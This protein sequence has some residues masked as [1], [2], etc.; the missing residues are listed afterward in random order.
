MFDITIITQKEYINPKIK[1]WYI[2]QIIEEDEL[3]INELEKLNLK[4]NRVNWDANHQWTSTKVIVVRAIWDYFNRFE[5]F[6][7]WFNLAKKQTKFINN[8]NL[9]TWNIDKKYLKEL[10]LKGVNI[11][12][13]LI[14]QK[15]D[16]TPLINLMEKL[17]S[18]ELVLKPTVSGAARHTYRLNKMNFKQ[19]E[20]IFNNLIANE[21]MMLQEFQRNIME[22][23][24]LSLMCFNGKF[25]HAVKK[26]AK[27]GDFRV[28]D[29]FGGSVDQY[30]PNTYEIQFAEEVMAN[31]PVLPTYGRVDLFYDNFKKLALGEVEVIEPEL[32][33]RYNEQAAKK[34]ANAIAMQLK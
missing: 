19:I 24:E 9:I 14:V 26:I 31:C 20:T 33:L 7:N 11:P 17:N 29:D 12:P 32:W 15:G 6:F 21:D 4:V 10:E 2:N 1:D 34:M 18:A 16:K 27:S 3:L 22:F 30:N 28:Q 5:E 25:S 8:A 23:G 13:T